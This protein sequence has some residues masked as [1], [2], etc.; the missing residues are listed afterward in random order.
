MGAQA[1][2]RK[3]VDE[4]PVTLCHNDAHAQNLFSLRRRVGTQET[5]ALDWE[6]AGMGPVATDITYLVIATLRRF[7]VDVADADELES[8]VLDGYLTGLERSG[9]RGDRATIELGFTAALAL[10]IGLVPQTL[11]IIMNAAQ[12]AHQERTWLRPA[13]ELI[14]RWAQVAHF[15]LDRVGRA[16]E[17]MAKR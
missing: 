2:F 10:R 16:R 6:L 5:V 12:R 4:L 9:W 14:A 7:A 1:R 15:V 17:L 8:V 13:D 3:I 11:G